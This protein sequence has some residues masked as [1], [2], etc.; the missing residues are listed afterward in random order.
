MGHGIAAC[1]APGRGQRV[2]LLQ[3]ACAHTLRLG[4]AGLPSEAE[5]LC[6]S[7][8]VGCGAEAVTSA[9]RWTSPHLGTAEFLCTRGPGCNEDSPAELW[10]GFFW[11]VFVS[12]VWLFGLGHGSFMAHLVTQ[13][14]GR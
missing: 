5:E 7:Q 3:G 10:V 13:L 4:E 14:S 8:R 2:E 9:E 12:G 11:V 1:P 6:A